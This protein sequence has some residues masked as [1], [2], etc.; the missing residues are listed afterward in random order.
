MKLLRNKWL[1]SLTAIGL[2]I[3]LAAF[4]FLASSRAASTT[5]RGVCMTARSKTPATESPWARL[6]TICVR[7]GV[8]MSSTRRAPRRSTSAASPR[9]A[10]APNTT[11]VGSDT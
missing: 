11:R 2:V 10:P 7:P 6:R 3:L 1:L 4:T 5:A 9:I 8:E